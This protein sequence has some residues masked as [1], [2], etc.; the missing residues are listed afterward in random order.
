MERIEKVWGWTTELFRNN[1]TSTHYLEIKK[2]GYCSEHRHAQKSNIFFVIEGT[3]EISKWF[4]GQRQTIEIDHIPRWNSSMIDPNI[5][6]KFHALTHVKCIE[7]Y[8]YLY[9]GVDIE[10]RTVGGLHGD[11]N[12]L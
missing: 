11:S 12:D 5:W 10:R 8:E 3:L 9:D 2:G 6:H 1:T 4:D 7:V